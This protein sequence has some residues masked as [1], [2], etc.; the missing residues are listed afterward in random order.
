MKQKPIASASLRGVAGG[1]HGGPILV[2]RHG[3]TRPGRAMISFSR[4]SLIRC[5]AG[6]T[7]NFSNSIELGALTGRKGARIMQVSHLQLEAGCTP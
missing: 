5:N 7:M 3:T 1:G 2:L 4:F 6:V